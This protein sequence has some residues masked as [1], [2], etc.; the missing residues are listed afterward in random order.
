MKRAPAL[1]PNQFKVN[2]AWIAFQ[3]NDETIHTVQDGSFDIVCLMDAAS[4]YIFGNAFV[5]LG[6]GEPTQFDARRLLKS[7]W[8][9]KK[10]YPKKLLL[11]K[12][13]FKT[14]L[15]VEAKRQRISVMSVPER[16]L[17]PFIDEARQGFKE[18]VERETE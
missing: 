10:Q 14:T 7:G 5:P 18:H 3:L 6:Q 2:E 17:L 8:V 15:P 9:H 12:G 1:H 4:C 11:P 13:Q 16:Q